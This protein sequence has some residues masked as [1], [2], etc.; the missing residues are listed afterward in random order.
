M[1]PLDAAVPDPALICPIGAAGS[2]KRT[3][4][5]TWPTT[6]VLELDAFRAMVSDDFSVKSSMLNK[7]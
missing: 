7:S 6:R 3:W 1:Q 2:G 4:A 5:S